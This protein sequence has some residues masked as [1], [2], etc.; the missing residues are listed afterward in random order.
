[1][2]YYEQVMGKGG[3]KDLRTVS[4][5]RLGMVLLQH[6]V[7]YEK[8]LEGDVVLDAVPV[9]SSQTTAVAW[10]SSACGSSWRRR[11][12]WHETKGRSGDGPSSLSTGQAAPSL[13]RH[14]G[15]L[16]VD[17]DP[18]SGAAPNKAEG[19]TRG[20]GSSL[21]QQGRRHASPTHRPAATLGSSPSC[22]FS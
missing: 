22:F 19:G 20:L 15:G 1:M 8:H 16:Q 9:S 2:H 6:E 3:K 13:G 17:D 11:R 14:S 10:R 4:W 12:A 21:P 18:F 5:Q 7:V